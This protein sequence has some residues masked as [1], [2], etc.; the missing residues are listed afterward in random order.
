MT[1]V[2]IAVDDSE[3]SV[4]AARTAAE[5]FGDS[6]EYLVVNVAQSLD[7][8][9]PWGLAMPYH[10]DFGIGLYAVPV[11]SSRPSGYEIADEDTDPAID[12]AEDCATKVADEADVDAVEVVA[13]VG[14]PAAA[15][16]EAAHDHLVDV[17]VVGS[18]KKNWFQ[19][20]FAGSVRADVVAQSDIPVLVV[21]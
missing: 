14:D 9:L 5:L 7:S 13:A 8:T 19:R 1:R 11:T 18:H 16:V 6:A 20:L 3:D 12:Q 2:L 15:I 10:P 21:T 17:I 4:Q